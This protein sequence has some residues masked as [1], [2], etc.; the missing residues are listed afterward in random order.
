MRNQKGFSAIGWM[1]IIGL[2]GLAMMAFIAIV[3]PYVD[4]I[5][6]EDALKSLA[7]NH[8]D[9][10]QMGKR[11]IHSVIDKFLAVNNINQDAAKSFEVKKFGGRAIVNSVYEV[12]SNF[13]ANIDVVVRFEN[14]LD[15]NNAGACC[16]YL[17]KNIDEEK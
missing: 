5:Y 7:E 14:Q 2:G 15:S 11:E 13:A 9:F 12:R 8:P 6:V 3:P 4:N 10:G 1:L 17:V 16:E